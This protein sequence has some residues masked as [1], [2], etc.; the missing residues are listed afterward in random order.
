MS[1][2]FIHVEHYVEHVGMGMNGIMEAV[3]L[4]NREGGILFH[5]GKI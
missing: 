1:S 2:S 3:P 4:V 5:Y